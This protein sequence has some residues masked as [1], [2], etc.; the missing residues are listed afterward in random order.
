[1]RV[2]GEVSGVDTKLEGIIIFVREKHNSVR[3]SPL[4]SSHPFLRKEGKG[5]GGR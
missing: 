5:E 2:E 3:E 4:D 1:M